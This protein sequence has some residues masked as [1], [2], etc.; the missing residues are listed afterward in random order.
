MLEKLQQ[1]MDNS[2]LQNLYTSMSQ[3]SRVWSKHEQTRQ[4]FNQHVD[5]KKINYKYQKRSGQC[6]KPKI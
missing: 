1:R 2:F 5:K 6:E 4:N 3:V